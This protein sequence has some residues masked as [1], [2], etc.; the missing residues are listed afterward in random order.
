[1]EGKK[2]SLSPSLVP[3]PLWGLSAYNLLRRSV[4]KRIRT[5]VLA[6]AQ[7]R[8][9]VCGDQH[10]T[11][12]VC[13]EVWEYNDQ[14]HVATLTR[15]SIACPDCDA[16]QHLGRTG[17][18]GYTK[19]ALEHMSRINGTTLREAAEMARE[20]SGVWR[21]RS[22]DSWTTRVAPS[23]RHRWPELEVLDGLTG[24]PG[25][26]RSRVPLNK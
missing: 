25:T 10:E 7:S 11:R 21:R 1:M 15:F 19:Q 20:V 17:Q 8:C 3:E 4:W 5:E 12:M 26:G 16:A 24:T 2:P 23:L 6:E 9:A 14:G 18:R 13:H 22:L